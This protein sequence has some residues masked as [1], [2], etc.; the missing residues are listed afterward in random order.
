MARQ[1]R[2]NAVDDGQF[3]FD[4]AA[5][6]AHVS[7]DGGRVG[8]LDNV[9]LLGRGLCV[10]EKQRDRGAEEC[11]LGESLQLFCEHSEPSL[12]DA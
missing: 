5:D 7:R 11:A 2:G 6:E 10:A 9:V 8:T 1:A 4:F 3:H 12:M